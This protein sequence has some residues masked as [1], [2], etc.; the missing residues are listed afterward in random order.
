M[1][2]IN[3]PDG[4]P[5]VYDA[6]EPAQPNVAVLLLHDWH[7]QTAAMASGFDELGKEL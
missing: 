7:P 3:A 1:S 4:T 6:Y 5:L 2:Q